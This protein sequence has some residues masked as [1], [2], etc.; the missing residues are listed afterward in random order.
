MIYL[1]VFL[2]S[3][4]LTYLIKEYAIKKSL[5]DIPNH[6]S[7]HTTATPHGGGIA[8][9]ISWFVGIT[10]LYFSGEIAENLF[11]AFLAGII[12][13]VVSFFDDM[14]EI[15]PKYRLLAQVIVGACGLY[16]L[17]GLD[18][19]NLLVFSIENQFLTNTIAFFIIVWCI[20]LYNFLDG[21][22]GYAGSEA[23]FLGV[24]G[25]LLFGESYFLVLVFS[26]FG[27]LVFN[28]HKAKIFMGDVGST[29]LGYNVA[30]FALHDAGEGSSLLIWIILFGLFWFDAT[31]TLLRRY[32]NKEQVTKAHNKHAY[33]RLTQ[34]GWSHSKVVLAAMGVNI[35]LFLLVYFFS[36]IL[37][38][39]FISV[40]LLYIIVKFVDNKKA[41][42]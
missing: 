14:Y 27:F 35:I 42:I 6:R 19:I 2:F 22:D 28:W 3:L 32:K 11:F 23:V 15:S 34:S 20:N 29:L 37:L 38:V 12:I 40:F 39:F 8:I 5:L 26:V 4:V 33:Q 7:A 36:N 1:T 21:I 30:I 9:A 17:G 13:S 25:F 18:K 10:F 31:L 16:F 41:F 24:A